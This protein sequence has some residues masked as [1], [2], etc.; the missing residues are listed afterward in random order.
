[1]A[2]TKKSELFKMD[3]NA[4]TG[5]ISVRIDNVILDDDVEISRTANRHCVFPLL[6]KKGAD[7]EWQHSDSDISNENAKVQAV[8]T[9]LWTDDVKEA[10][11]KEVE[12]TL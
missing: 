4:V 9:A 3:V 8:A 2:L 1:M 6:S 11:Q 12:K 10:F 5:V 7:G